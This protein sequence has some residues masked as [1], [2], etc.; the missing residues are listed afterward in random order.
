MPIAIMNIIDHASTIPVKNPIQRAGPDVKMVLTYR[1]PQTTHHL[2][3]K[4]QDACLDKMMKNAPDL[5]PRLQKIH[6]RRDCVSVICPSTNA[7]QARL[8]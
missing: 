1:P 5:P 8:S 2:L 7:C 6:P 3:N 4:C